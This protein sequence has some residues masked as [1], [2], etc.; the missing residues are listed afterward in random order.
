[1][2]QEWKM[3]SDL[4]WQV[5][6][7]CSTSGTP[8]PHCSA[9]ALSRNDGRGLQSCAQQP[10]ASPLDTHAGCVPVSPVA[11]MMGISGCCSGTLAQ[12]PLPR[13]AFPTWTPPCGSVFGG[14]SWTLKQRYK[15]LH[16]V[17]KIVLVSSFP[18]FLGNKERSGGAHLS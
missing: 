16:T 12:P 18:I 13:H 9:A 5:C 2:P 6:A 8:E 7:L 10:L 14:N 15:T 4:S 1:M 17:A 3:V 11:P